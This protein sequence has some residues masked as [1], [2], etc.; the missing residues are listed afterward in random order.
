MNRRQAMKTSFASIGVLS[1]LSEDLLGNEIDIESVPDPKKYRLDD[2]KIG[3]TCWCTPPTTD[4]EYV[5]AEPSR[6]TVIAWEEYNKNR[7]RQASDHMMR[8]NIPF[9]LNG[10][11][12]ACCSIKTPCGPD[13][14]YYRTR[15]DAIV[16]KLKRI[17]Q[18]QKRH[19][20]Q[21]Q[22]GLKLLDGH[23]FVV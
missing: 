7:P 15:E 5:F 6:I 8:H 17:N 9:R 3:E 19:S 10:K 2:F 18:V 11:N 23:K 20:Q 22:D 13:Y 16:A 21:I 4:P 14:F 1:V 12:T